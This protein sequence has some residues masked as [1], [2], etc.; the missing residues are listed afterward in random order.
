MVSACGN[1][2]YPVIPELCMELGTE[3]DRRTV[4]CVLSALAN[5]NAPLVLQKTH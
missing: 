4:I 2:I 1:Y 5:L 3:D